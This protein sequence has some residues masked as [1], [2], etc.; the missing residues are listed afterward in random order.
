MVRASEL[1]K[2]LQTLIA[3]HGDHPVFMF[4]DFEFISGVYLETDQKYYAVEHNNGEP[5]FMVN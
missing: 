4:G 1:V 3:K 5:V 2:E